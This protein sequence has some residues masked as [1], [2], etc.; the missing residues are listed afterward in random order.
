MINEQEQ[1]PFDAVAPDL[2]PVVE[3]P[4]VEVAERIKPDGIPEAAWVAIQSIRNRP[5]QPRLF[6]NNPV[7]THEQLLREQDAI[8][9]RAML[10]R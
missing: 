3:E 9:T 2:A 4:F 8:H 7:K 1:L 6:P 5:P 10:K